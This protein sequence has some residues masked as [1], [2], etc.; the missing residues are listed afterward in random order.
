MTKKLTTEAFIERAREVHDDKY[1]YSKV[2]YVETH[3]KVNIICPEHGSFPQTPSSHLQGNGCP[4][5]GANKT[6]TSKNK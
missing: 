4:G 2:A 5:C 6:K 1:D 3:Q